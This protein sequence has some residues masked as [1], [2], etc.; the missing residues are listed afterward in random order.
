MQVKI[1]SEPNNLLNAV[2]LGARNCYHAGSPLDIDV[3]NIPED[4][5]IKLVT[6][7]LKMGHTSIIEH[8]AITFAIEGI[9]RACYD[10]MTQVL[11]KQGWKYFK[12][13]DIDTDQFATRNEAGF[14]EFHKATDYIYYNY[15]G[16]MHHY[17]KT[18]LDLMVTP[19]HNMYIKKA[20]TRTPQEY[21]LIPSEDISIKN[22]YVSRV[23]NYTNR[24]SRT[25]KIDGYEY[26]KRNN[27]GGITLKKTPDLV[28]SKKTFLPFMAW[29]LSDGSTYHNVKENSY[30]I[31]IAQ[32]DCRENIRNRTKE[33][34]SKLISSLGLHPFADTRAVMVKNL[35]LGKFLKKLGKSYEKHIPWDIFLEFNQQY[36]KIFIDE[37]FKGD[38]SI[39]QYKNGTK[40]GKLYTSSPVL[41]EQLEILCLMAGYTCKMYKKEPKGYLYIKGQQVED[42]YP[43]YIINVSLN[44]E[45]HARNR[46]VL[47]NKNRDFSEV[48]YDGKVYC[49]TVPNHTLFVKRNGTSVWC[50]NCLAQLTRHRVG[51]SYSVQS[52]R[53]VELKEDREYIQSLLTKYPYDRLL[54]TAEKYFVLD[55]AENPSIH[56]GKDEIARLLLKSIDNYL[57]AI[58]MGAPAEDARMFLPNA[59]KTN[60]VLT[61]NLR[62]LSNFCNE[63]LCGKAQAEIR[64]LANCLKQE[65]LLHYDWYKDFLVPKCVKN[66]KCTEKVSCKQ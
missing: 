17:S 58:E 29:Y 14:V 32:T 39:Y 30:C 6:Q 36:A 38:G 25:I 43:R 65:V 16:I 4:K 49:V 64:Q 15:N 59:M 47:I 8:N 44:K 63:R 55:W 12:D 24:V 20:T 57:Y 52:Q 34:I 62:A 28:L 18:N 46:E 53:Y 7:I 23:F 9:S 10:D 5:K 56:M 21:R 48:M 1:I 27:H 61:T 33:R 50:G 35:T 11:T 13:I 31:T 40:C 37:Y 2:Y 22:F 66:G 54:E 51:F 19:N 45:L 3:D 60:V 26:T 42:K 41:A